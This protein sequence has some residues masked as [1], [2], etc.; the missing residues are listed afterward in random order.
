MV[1]MSPIYRLADPTSMRERQ[2][3][4]FGRIHAD[5]ST[6]PDPDKVTHRG[7]DALVPV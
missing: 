6:Q 3:G 7:R 5:K 4:E 1:T 2:L